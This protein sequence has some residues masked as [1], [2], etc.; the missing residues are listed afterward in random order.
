MDIEAYLFAVFYM[1][2]LSFT[3]CLNETRQVTYI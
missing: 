3:L 2:F 1:S